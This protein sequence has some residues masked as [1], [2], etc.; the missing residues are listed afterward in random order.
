MA[1]F[2]RTSLPHSIS[3]SMSEDAM[4]GEE[5]PKTARSVSVCDE[6]QMP[7]SRRG[8]GGE[9]D[10]RYPPVLVLSHPS[11]QKMATRLVQATTARTLK[12]KLNSTVS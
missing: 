6:H 11:M 8:T 7:S 10:G 12:L 5:N 9:G 3:E 1:S 2:Q 4:D